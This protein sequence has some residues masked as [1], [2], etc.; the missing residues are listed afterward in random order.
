MVKR[1]A[2]VLPCIGNAAPEA[3]RI[4]VRPIPA[5]GLSAVGPMPELDGYYVAVTHSGVTLS[6]IL[7]Q[8]VANELVHGVCEPCLAPFRPGRLIG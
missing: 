2:R 6:P 5:D 7:A 4:G 8:L 1:A 3:V